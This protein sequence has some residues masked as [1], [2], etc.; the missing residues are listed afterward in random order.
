MRRDG[1]GC[2]IVLSTYTI[3]E[4]ESNITDRNFLY[5]HSFTYLVLDEAHALKN[6]SSHR[7][8]NLNLIR[9]QRRLLLSGTPV[10]NSPSDLWTLV[11]LVAPGVLGGERAFQSRVAQPVRVAS[12]AA[13]SRTS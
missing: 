8:I 5:K 7:F 2:D 10:Q 4:R 6:S 13:A 9:S 3:F 1:W 12:R 11:D